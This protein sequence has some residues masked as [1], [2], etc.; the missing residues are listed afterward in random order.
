M[1]CTSTITLVIKSE[2]GICISSLCDKYCYFKS[3][4][5]C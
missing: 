2:D 3:F 5:I 4:V 1:K